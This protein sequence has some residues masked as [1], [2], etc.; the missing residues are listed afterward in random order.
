MEPPDAVST[1]RPA[2]ACYFMDLILC[3]AGGF[4]FIADFL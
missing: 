2:L 3:K 4:G 1:M